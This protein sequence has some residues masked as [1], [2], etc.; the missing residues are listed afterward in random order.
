MSKTSSQERGTMLSSILNVKK[1]EG[2]KLKNVYIIFLQLFFISPYC[3]L[4]NKLGIFYP[5]LRTGDDS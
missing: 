1:L 4:P 3:L 2:K 5:S